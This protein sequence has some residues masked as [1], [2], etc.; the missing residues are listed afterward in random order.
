M[1]GRP[2][3][4]LSVDNTHAIEN[5]GSLDTRVISPSD[6]SSQKEF[7]QDRLGAA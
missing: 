5:S 1:A 2:P 7:S 6:Q 3:N 4:S